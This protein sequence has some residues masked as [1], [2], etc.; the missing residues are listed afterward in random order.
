MTS[1]IST[2]EFTD[3]TEVKSYSKKPLSL[4][5]E[6]IHS[7]R[8]DSFEFEEFSVGSRKCKWHIAHSLES[9]CDGKISFCCAEYCQA[10]AVC[11]LPPGPRCECM[12]HKRWLLLLLSCLRSLFENIDKSTHT[13]TPSDA[14]AD[15]CPCGNS[16]CGSC[17]WRIVVCKRITSALWHC[18]FH[19]W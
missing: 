9:M 14:T 2:H 16:G 17:C 8:I 4:L 3:A 13:H 7:R 1:F 15:I 19:C 12:Q 18:S 11:A 10:H 5:V 6:S